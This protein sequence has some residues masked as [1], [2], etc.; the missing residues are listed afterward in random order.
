MK[1]DNVPLGDH[2]ARN[3]P[4]SKLLKDEDDNVLGFLGEAFKMRPAERTL[5]ATWVEYFG[6]TWCQQ[7]EQAVRAT[8]ASSLDV[9]PKSAFAIGNVGA[10]KSA[11][12]EKSYKVRIVHEPTEDNDAHV[13]VRRMPH[14]DDDLFNLLALDAWS[15]LVKNLDIAP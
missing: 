15:G 10:I 12:S 11:C 13:A 4:W 9:K 3:V 2:V 8:R 14:D 1:G 5:S 7:V 6:G